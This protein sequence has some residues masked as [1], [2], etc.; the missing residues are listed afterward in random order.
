[1]AGPTA[2]GACPRLLSI[3]YLIAS[4][5]EAMTGALSAGRRR[6]D[7]FGVVMIACVTALGGGSLRD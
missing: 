5:A 6:M 3:I 1:M 4:S 7:L 2:P